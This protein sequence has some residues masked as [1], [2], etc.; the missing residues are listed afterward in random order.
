MLDL[1]RVESLH[2][3]SRRTEKIYP[4]WGLQ[5]N[6]A[7][8]EEDNNKVEPYTVLLQG[9]DKSYIKFT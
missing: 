4:C 9:L 6:S 2:S 5:K 3:F 8:V 7:K 1:Q